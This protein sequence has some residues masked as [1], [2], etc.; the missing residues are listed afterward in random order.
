MD[1]LD[2]GTTGPGG[3]LSWTRERKGARSRPPLPPAPIWPGCKDAGSGVTVS[4]SKENLE[5]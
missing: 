4:S 2:E 3:L 5:L 1:V